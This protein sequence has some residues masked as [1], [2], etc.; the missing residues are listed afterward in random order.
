MLEI[1]DDEKENALD[2]HSEIMLI[3]CAPINSCRGCKK[4]RFGDGCH[5][6]CSYMTGRVVKYYLQRRKNPETE[7]AFWRDY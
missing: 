3:T 6:V 5:R 1:P 2:G 4:S 7:S